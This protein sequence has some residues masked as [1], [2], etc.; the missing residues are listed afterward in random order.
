MGIIDAPP[1]I[2]RVEDI[3]DNPQ[4]FIDG[5]SATDV[6]QGSSGDCWFLAALMAVSAKKELVDRLCVARNERA[7][8]Y[9]F[10]FYRDGEWIHEV[11]DDK[12]FLRV[13]DD[14]DLNVVRDWDKDGKGGMG[15]RH[16]EDKLKT[17]L[18]RGGEALYFSHCKSNETWL[19]LME[20]AFAKAHGD[21]CAIEGGFASEAIE[22]LTGGVGVVLNPEDIMDK[23]RF[24]REQ[25]SQVNVKYLFGGGSK[26]TSA[27]GFVG[28]HAYAVLQAWEEGD[29]KLLKLRN[30]WGRTEWEGDWSDG[31]KLWTPEMMQKLGHRFGD[32]GIFWI[33][34]PDFLKHFPSINR[35]RLFNSD[36]QVSQ[37][38]TSV[39]VP[40]TVDYLDTKF[41]FT[42]E[43]KCPVVIVLSQ[44]DDRYWY[45]VRGR[46]LFALHFRVVKEGEE[47]KWIVR[48]LHNSGNETTFTRSVSAEIED[49]EPGTYSVLVK[50]TATRTSTPT[51]E[52]M[53]FKSA[54]DRKEKLL[55]VGRR[56]DYAQT[57][58]NLRGLE[59][60]NKRQ[61]RQETRS[62]DLQG[63]KAARR[64]NQ[65]VKE[66]MRKCKK[67]I[68]DATRVKRR[69]LDVKQREKAKARKARIAEKQA[70]KK[71]AK[72]EEGD[73][74]ES[75]EDEEGKD[76]KTPPAGDEAEAGDEES[77]DEDEESDDEEEDGDVGEGS[78]GK[79]SEA[80][81]KGMS[82]LEIGSK[83]SAEGSPPGAV[84]PIDDR[85][86]QEDDVSD[87]EYESSVEQLDEL[88]DEDF[89]WDSDM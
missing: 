70:A 68:D 19:P 54:I 77:E 36:W 57:K 88:E 42:I 17:S 43:K 39:N 60:A 40:W 6:H 1:W 48:S 31:S 9:G 71:A 65:K 61:F 13:G 89:D 85:E 81:S 21:Y 5:A 15:L 23:D 18:Q 84:S 58:G 59:D 80:I 56:F 26:P 76:E 10:V 34:L 55:H 28:S 82:K 52:E 22:D 49:L 33:S 50:V 69:E 4:F 12:L 73:D 41:Q 44:P 20:K 7:G 86:E 75:N 14:D 16:D 78:K 45:G 53:I 51:A 29:L 8:V 62:Q 87:S 30:P 46:F 66:R 67:R 47:D 3:F 35:V 74:G 64:Y 83:T 38:W 2:K 79:Q 24:W 27:K 63:Y 72:A 32:D 37:Q 11:I 25:L